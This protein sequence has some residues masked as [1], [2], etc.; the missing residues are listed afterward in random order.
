MQDLPKELWGGV[1]GRPAA[2]ER[3]TARRSFPEAWTAVI[4]RSVRLCELE[5]ATDKNSDSAFVDSPG[6]S[7]MLALVHKQFLSQAEQETVKRHFPEPH[8]QHSGS[9]LQGP[10]VF[11]TFHG[12]RQRYH[13]WQS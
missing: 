6:K 11:N 7:Y 5:E 4:C 2:Q 1:A 9:D 10:A 13:L 12:S 8:P 3:S